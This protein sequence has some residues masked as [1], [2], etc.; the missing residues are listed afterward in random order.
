MLCDSCECMINY[1]CDLSFFFFLLLLECL[2]VIRYKIISVTCTFSYSRLC[3]GP[4]Y[5]INPIIAKIGNVSED[6]SNVKSLPVVTFV[7]NG[8]DYPLEPE[9]YVIKED[10]KCLLGMESMLL[11]TPFFIMGTV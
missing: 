10:G 8:M 3:L 1:M 9:F 2:T 7:F 4:P 11:T 6:C 5:A